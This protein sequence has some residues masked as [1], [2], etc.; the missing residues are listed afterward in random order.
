MCS[1][2]SCVNVV[3]I[4][5]YKEDLRE[6]IMRAVS[7]AEAN[8]QFSQLL[9]RVRSGHRFLVTSHGHPVAKLVPV[10]DGDTVA[11]QARSALVGRLESTPVVD[12][13]TW[14]RDQLYERS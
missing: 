11:S 7:A 12:V 1:P 2:A 10:D 8:R 4:T 14:T 6:S 9:R 13:E 5:T 3:I